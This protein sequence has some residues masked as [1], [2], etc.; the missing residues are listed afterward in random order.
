MLEMIAE[1]AA[2]I[3]HQTH[4]NQHEGGTQA[5]GGAEA[6]YLVRAFLSIISNHFSPAPSVGCLQQ[7]P[8]MMAVYH[9]NTMLG[10]ESRAPLSMASPGGGLMTHGT[11][12]WHLFI[13]VTS[14]AAYT[15]RKMVIFR[16]VEPNCLGTNYNSGG[17][18]QAS[19]LAGLGDSRFCLT[20]HFATASGK[21]VPQSEENTPRDNTTDNAII[22]KPLRADL[23]YERVHPGNVACDLRHGPK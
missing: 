23:F 22:L 7:H 8:T 4:V 21:Q 14:R 15:V 10:V 16:L 19:K 13:S 6:I 1:R 9:G 18:I 2:K 11:Y 5:Q 12:L 17:A 20:E 3:G